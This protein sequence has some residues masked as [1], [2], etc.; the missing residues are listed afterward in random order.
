MSKFLP[1]S[2]INEKLHIVLDFKCILDSV[3][4]NFFFLIIIIFNSEYDVTNYRN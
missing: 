4:S 1:Y 2:L 3:P